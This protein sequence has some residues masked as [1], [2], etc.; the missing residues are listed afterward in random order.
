MLEAYA[1]LT[2]KMYNVGVLMSGVATG[3]ASLWGPGTPTRQNTGTGTPASTAMFF[4]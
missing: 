4:T 1:E 2:E 3:D